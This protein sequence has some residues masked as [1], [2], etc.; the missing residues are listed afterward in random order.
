MVDYYE[1]LFKQSGTGKHYVHI[2]RIAS[3]CFGMLAIVLAFYIMLLGKSL[4]EVTQIISAIFFAPLG[5]C[6]FLGIFTKKANNV[7]VVT[8]VTAGVAVTLVSWYL[9]YAKIV[10]INFTW[11]GVF[12]ILTTVIVG[13]C[14][15]IVTDKFKSSNFTNIKEGTERT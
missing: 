9:N 1:R 4:V 15:S 10:L 12:G 2:S 6:F 5:G 11:F 3:F 14:V 8:G 7:G 13:Y